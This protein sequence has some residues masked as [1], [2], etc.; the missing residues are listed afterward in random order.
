MSGGIFFLH[1]F[2][3]F[4]EIILG[5]HELSINS[6]FSCFFPIQQQPLRLRLYSAPALPP[7]AAAPQRQLFARAAADLGY[8]SAAGAVRL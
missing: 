5:A 1:R 7:V 2:W 8:T 3:E 6:H 4:L